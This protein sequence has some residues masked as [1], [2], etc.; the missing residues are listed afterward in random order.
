MER[1]FNEGQK[2]VLVRLLYQALNTTTLIPG[3]V[4]LFACFEGMAIGDFWVLTSSKIDHG[5]T[6]SLIQTPGFQYIAN[7]SSGSKM[8]SVVSC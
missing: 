4:L 8:P 2:W 5:F 3:L 6:Y 7:L 1:Y